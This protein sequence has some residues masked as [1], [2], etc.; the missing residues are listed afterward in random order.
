MPLKLCFQAT[1]CTGKIHP[2]LSIFFL[3]LTYLENTVKLYC[4]NQLFS[5]FRV[6]QRGASLVLFLCLLGEN[7]ARAPRQNK[8]HEHKKLQPVPSLKRKGKAQ[9]ELS[10]EEDKNQ[11]SG[12]VLTLIQYYTFFFAESRQ[13]FKLQIIF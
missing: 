13:L 10:Y 6:V 4:N 5:Y 9:K 12:H 8:I 3:H 1:E 11:K 2:N 7:K